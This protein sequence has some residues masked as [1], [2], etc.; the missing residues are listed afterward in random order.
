VNDRETWRFVL[1]TWFVSRVFFMTVGTL[2]YYLL[3]HV[4]TEVPEGPHGALNYWD[5]WDG[6]WYSSIAT[7]GYFKTLWPASANF[8]P[9][10]PLLLHVATTLGLGVAVAG[11]LISLVASLLALYFA[12]ELARDYFDS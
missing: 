2:G 4:K 1:L 10:Y 8:F 6:A 5:H 7:N 12:Y 3:S 9:F 11:V